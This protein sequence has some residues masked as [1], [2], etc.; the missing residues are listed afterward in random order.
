[1]ISWMNDQRCHIRGHNIPGYF[2]CHWTNLGH[3]KKKKK[4][5]TIGDTMEDSDTK[6]VWTLHV[7]WDAE[8]WMNDEA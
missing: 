4:K 1:M 7:G 6:Q 5:K 2:R 3:K 8:D